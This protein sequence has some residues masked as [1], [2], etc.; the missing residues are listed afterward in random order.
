[1][2]TMKYI[3]TH[4]I[5]STSLTRS[6][7]Q[8]IITPPPLPTRVP[9]PLLH[10]GSLLIGSIPTAFYSTPPPP[11][12]SRT[13]DNQLG[14]GDSSTIPRERPQ[15]SSRTHKPGAQIDSFESNFGQ[16]KKKT[17]ARLAIQFSASLQSNPLHPPSRPS[18]F[19]SSRSGAY[20][21]RLNKHPDITISNF[22]ASV[23]RSNQTGNLA[24]GI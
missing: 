17:G 9:G 4:H 24:S 14:G 12:H 1:M 22:L 19:R 11:S 5:H 8:D 3:H 15:S 10:T 20:S 6:C 21:S 16:A 18:V 7:L 23:N 13:L 2:T